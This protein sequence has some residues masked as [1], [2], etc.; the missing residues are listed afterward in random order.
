[1]MAT[2]GAQ[3]ADEGAEVGVER[4]TLTV[5]GHERVFHIYRPSDGPT[6]PYPV[7]IALHGGGGQALGM[8][9]VGF[10][11]VADR[12]GFVVVYPQGYNRGWN[13]GRLGKRIVSRADDAD[14]V[15]FVRRMIDT[16]VEEA[17]A[18]PARIYSTG[19]S[20]GGIMSYRIAC[21]LADRVAAVAP[22]IGNMPAARA[23]LCTPARPVPIFVINGTKDPLVHWE[24]GGIGREPAAS[25]G[26]LISV[27]QSVALWRQLNGCSDAHTERMLP[28]TS[29]EDGTRTKEFVWSECA[30]GAEIKLFRVEEGGHI[31]HG[32]E[33]SPDLVRI[34]R[35]GRPSLDFSG[36]EKIWAFFERHRLQP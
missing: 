11:P 30:D 22:V 1:M 18:D 12:E 23:E 16:L 35:V 25:G 5:D 32:L 7:V 19:P 26:Y 6:G 9:R 36:A 14:D 2:A 24:G 13:D 21:D 33:R 4:R 17:I 27:E 28:D 34:E 3:Q 29:T 31:W 20:N 15:A 8:R 10:E